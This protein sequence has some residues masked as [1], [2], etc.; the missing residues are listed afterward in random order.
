MSLEWPDVLGPLLHGESLAFDQAA[1]AMERIMLGEAT[2]AQFGAF[3]GA[4]R[5]KGETVDEIRGLVST[6]RRF[7]IRVDV[8]GPL[9]DTCGTGGDRAGTI[10][11]S[12]TAAFVVAG[13][14]GRVAK[15]GNR[16]ASSASGSADLLEEFGVKIDLGSDGVAACIEEAGIGFCFAPVFHPSMRHAGPHRKEL[17]VG[18]VFNFLGPLTNPA[19][20]LNQAIGT[21][22]PAM[23]S[24]MLQVL[25]ALGSERV[26]VFHGSDGLDEVTTTGPTWL[27][28]LR[29]GQ[30]TESELDVADLGVPRSS[31]ADLVGGTPKHNAAIAHEVL[32]GEAGPARDLVVVNAAAGMVAAGLAGKFDEGLALASESIDSGKAHRSLDSLV[33]V[34]NS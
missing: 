16:A 33:E 26:L 14:G 1:W 9:V 28:E 4:L 31:P 6:M 18:T 32:D 17:G 12:T 19:G 11:V 29:G 15:H 30:I 27:W 34:S 23:A 10:N 7:C 8:D 24:K 2:G 25:K 5:T 20:A 3:V 13:A 22:D 21:S